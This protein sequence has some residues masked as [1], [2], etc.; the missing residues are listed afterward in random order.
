MLRKFH[1]S[2]RYSLANY[3]SDNKYIHAFIQLES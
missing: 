2:Y 3:N 1:N